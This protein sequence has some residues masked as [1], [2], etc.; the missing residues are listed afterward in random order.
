VQ[1][2]EEAN[3]LSNRLQESKQQYKIDME[4]LKDQ[5]KSDIEKSIQDIIKSKD[6]EKREVIITLKEEQQVKLQSTQ[7]EYNKA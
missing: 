7:D 4:T 1:S 2:K 5:Q 3:K 6:A